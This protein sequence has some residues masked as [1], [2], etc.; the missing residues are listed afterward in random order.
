[1]MMILFPNICKINLF[2]AFQYNIQLLF[3]NMGFGYIVYFILG[4]ICYENRIIC[5]NRIWFY[6][7]AGFS[8]YMLI[9]GNW[10]SDDFDIFRC[11]Y[12]IGI[13]IIFQNIV[14][15]ITIQNKVKNILSIVSK[16]CFG[17][18]LVHAM[19][20][21]VIC[22]VIP[23]VDVKKQI[24]DIILTFIVSFIVVCGIGKLPHIGK[25]IL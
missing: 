10:Q 16:K 11:I 20:I 23:P 13:F 22:K 2:Q 19:I 6:I 17:I 5:K 25:Y 3:C 1:M 12:T 21:D 24:I 9:F 14:N 7:V 15:E 4:D 18:Y 8:A